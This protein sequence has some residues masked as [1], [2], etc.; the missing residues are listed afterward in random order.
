MR[1]HCE[2]KPELIDTKI[3]WNKEKIDTGN[4]KNDVIKNSVD[5]VVKNE[6]NDN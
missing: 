5:S 2:S 4:L 3:F 6:F 1:M